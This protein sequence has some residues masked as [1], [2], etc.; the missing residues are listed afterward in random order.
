MRR[1]AL[2]VLLNRPTSVLSPHFGKAKWIMFWDEDGQVSFEQNTAL[3][4]RAVVDLMT[5]KAC[6]DAVFTH[7]GAGAFAHLEKSGIQGWLG[8]AGVPAPEILGALS[9]DELE[10]ARPSEQEHASAAPHAE[11]SGANHSSHKSEGRCSCSGCH[12]S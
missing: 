4:G 7:I 9:R 10:K 1:I 3:N 6:T 12:S 2:A 11:D 8:P 5:K